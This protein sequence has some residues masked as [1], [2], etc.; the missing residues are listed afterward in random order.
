MK[1]RKIKIEPNFDMASSPL[2]DKNTLLSK[3]GISEFIASVALDMLLSTSE[4]NLALI[5]IVCLNPAIRT[6]NHYDIEAY[7]TEFDDK[8]KPSV[9]AVKLED[10]EEDD[11]DEDD[12]KATTAAATTKKR[13]NKIAKDDDLRKYLLEKREKELNATKVLIGGTTDQYEK[14]GAI[15]KDATMVREFVG[16]ALTNHH[17]CVYA[18]YVGP[19]YKGVNNAELRN[20]ANW[21]PVHK[22]HLGHFHRRLRNDVKAY[23]SQTRYDQWSFP[24]EKFENP[25]YDPR[26]IAH[27]WL[28]AK[29][30]KPLKVLLKQHVSLF[31]RGDAEK[32]HFVA[33]CES[34]KT[35]PSLHYYDATKGEPFAPVNTSSF[36]VEADRL[37]QQAQG[38]RLSDEALCHVDIDEFP[39]LTRI[40]LSRDITFSFEEY[41]LLAKRVFVENETTSIATSSKASK[42][43]DFYRWDPWCAVKATA[44]ALNPEM[45]IRRTP[46]LLADKHIQI[47]ECDNIVPILE[48]FA[49]TKACTDEVKDATAQLLYAT[50]ATEIMTREH[51]THLNSL[52]GEE[53]AGSFTLF[54]T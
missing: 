3:L 46:A 49:K 9:I 41:T 14:L 4:S 37:R 21:V 32:D 39:D 44:M 24:G 8:K 18:Y 40:P 31:I 54:D 47:L 5:Q 26:F 51:P 23:Y 7:R 12:D 33:S 52:L 11:D 20:P 6:L 48:H 42:P 15:E 10:D 53:N 19:S 45:M 30:N 25:S 1:H 13:K 27:K 17:Y 38:Y 43:P 16:F 2:L 35:P 22:N 34:G 28:I 36:D 29:E 50:M